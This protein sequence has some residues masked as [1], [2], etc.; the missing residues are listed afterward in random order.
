LKRLK[1]VSF[2]GLDLS[3]QM[4]R[5]HLDNPVLTAAGTSGHGAELADYFDISLLGAVVTKSVAIFSTPGN[6]APRLAPLSVG[7]LNSVGL[8]GDGIKDWLDTDLPALKRAGAKIICSIWGRT[9]EDFAE[10]MKILST[11]KKD[12]LAAEV[13]VSCPNVEDAGKLFAY[14]PSKTGEIAGAVKDFD[15]PFFIKLSPAASDLVKVAGAALENGAQGLVLVNTMPAMAIDIYE[16]KPKL[17]AVS[18]GLSGRALHPVA[19][20]AVYDCRKAFPDA[21]IIGVGGIGHGKDA[22][23]MMMA[24]ANAV[25]V[26]T[27]TFANPKAPINVL[28]EIGQFCFEEGLQ[29]LSD[30]VG[31]AFSD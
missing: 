5:V 10:A 3:C 9:V 20:K 30:I 13:N 29:K 21:S 2:D 23:A 16:R 7:M 24:G 27:A 4:G 31:V 15:V 11:A 1:K 8:Q 6:P 26:G 14:S 22:I 25:E 17:G 28:R 12:I 19:L 18:G